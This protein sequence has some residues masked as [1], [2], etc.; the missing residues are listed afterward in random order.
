MPADDL[1][2]RPVILDNGLRVVRVPL[3]HTRVAAI[4]LAMPGGAFWEADDEWG[5]AHLVEH[6]AMRGTHRHG[7]RIATRRVARRI[8]AGLNARTSREWVSVEIAGLGEHAPAMMDLA[9]E[10]AARPRMDAGDAALEADVVVQEIRRK[11]DGDKAL[12]AEAL[13]PAGFGAREG[14]SV[15][16][17]E[18][19]VRSFTPA[20]ISAFQAS[21]WQARGAVL[22]VAGALDALSDADLARHGSRLP[23]GASRERTTANADL[24]PDTVLLEGTSGQAHLRMFVDTDWNFSDGQQARAARRLIGTILSTRIDEEIRGRRRLV[25]SAGGGSVS[26]D[27][28]SRLLL[29]A[30][31]APERADEAL[32]VLQGEL[33]RMLDHPE[34]ITDDELESARVGA[35]TD[36]ADHNESAADIADALAVTYMADSTPLTMWGFSDTIA[37]LTRDNLVGE[38]ERVVRG[39]R[40]LAAVGAPADLQLPA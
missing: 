36:L 4:T 14:R 40:V 11:R 7:D 26:L 19:S 10:I 25:Y 21:T 20:Q 39:R 2:L 35:L 8:G 38:L 34:G 32:R 28:R 13:W 9:M 29:H 12:L 17:S 16:G 3:P 15:L 37:A 33:D 24:V 31:C 30:G 5:L 1:S 22:V 6:V 27:A 18:D 23:A